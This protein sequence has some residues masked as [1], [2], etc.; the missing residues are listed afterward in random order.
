MKS[1]FPSILF[2]FAAIFSL[3]ACNQAPNSPA[4]QPTPNTQ[5]TIDASVQATLQAQSEIETTIDQAVAATLTAQPTPDYATFSEEELAALI[6]QAVAEAITASETASASTTSATSDGTV[7]SEEINYTYTYVYDSAYAIAYAEELIS[8]Y[9]DYYGVYAE[10]TL[11]ELQQIE[12]DLAAISGS[13]EEIN[14][15]L[16]QGA[17]AATAAIEQLNAA[18]ASAQA[19]LS[20]AQAKAETWQTQIQTSLNQRETDL[21]N[22]APTE[23]ATDKIG[24]LNQAHD[25]LETFKT[26]LGDGKFSPEELRNVGQLSANVRASF[27]GL[28][29]RSGEFGNLQD[30]VENLTRQAARG[31]WGSAK[32]SL[33]EFERSLPERPARPSRP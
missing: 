3:F 15:I 12:Q 5:A 22:L 8:A 31:D 19:Q 11:T 18:A 32:S 29:G 25:F 20:A 4:P 16:D 14:A 13:L 6:D 27:E 33:G 17:E 26:A 28:G 30:A 23:I 2:L 10:A 7:T 9:Y 1:K 24:A 21:L